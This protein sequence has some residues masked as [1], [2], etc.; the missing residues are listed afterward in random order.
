MIMDERMRELAF[1][2]WRRA[3]LIRTGKFVELV[4][5]RNDWTIEQ[6]GYI[7]ENKIHWPVPL[8]EITEFGWTQ[9]PGY[10]Q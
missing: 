6:P 4:K 8:T 3:D 9:N 7:N 5:S 2:G 10:I 1:E